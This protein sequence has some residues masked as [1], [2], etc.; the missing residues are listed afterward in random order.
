[1]GFIPQP[2]E[3][4]RR[5]YSQPTITSVAVADRRKPPVG[6]ASHVAREA[7]AAD[8]T[9]QYVATPSDAWV[10]KVTHTRDGYS[11]GD[12]TS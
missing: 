3:Y 11:L 4:H 12:E 9:G 5:K 6:P 7:R 1:M 8:K 2:P 10:H